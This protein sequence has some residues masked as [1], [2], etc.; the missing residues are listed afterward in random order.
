[1][2]KYESGVKQIPYPQETVY[3]KLS[4]LENIET[5]KDN[6]PLDKL[7]EIKDL[8]FDRDSVSVSI[9]PIGSITLCVVEREEPKCIKFETTNSPVP[10]T[11][12][13]QLL[14]VTDTT[15]K[16]RLTLKADVPFFLK[17]MIGNR[18]GEMVDQVA[19]ALASIP[20]DG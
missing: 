4:N 19:E 14:P 13:I 17:P 1:M 8:S 16:M 15:S 5:L 20:Y 18:L 7:N 9:P 10:I 11:L 12:W 3:E 6:I 2:S